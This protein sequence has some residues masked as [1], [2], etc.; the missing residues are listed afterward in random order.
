MANRLI[1]VLKASCVLVKCGIQ[2]LRDLAEVRYR[3]PILSDA[4]IAAISRGAGVGRSRALEWDRLIRRFLPD[5]PLPTDFSSGPLRWQIDTLAW[6]FRLDPDM[7]L[8]SAEALDA[9]SEALTLDEP[10]R[11]N[12]LES[13]YPAIR[14]YATF[15]ERIPVRD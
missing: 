11:P 2:L 14:E 7:T 5:R 3:G 1:P 12:P 13:T 6:S 8:T 4:E 10:V 15:L 9:L